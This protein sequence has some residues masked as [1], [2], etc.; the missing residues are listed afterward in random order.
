MN[1]AIIGANGFIGKHLVNQLS[2]N[3]FNQL[4]LFGT[5]KV[6]PFSN[7]YWYSS[8]DLKNTAELLSLFKDIDIVY[9]LASASIPAS[10]WENPIAEIENNLL[11]FINFLECISKL[12][13]K[14]IIF[15]SSAGTIYGSSNENLSEDSNKKPFSPHGINK[16][17]M[18]YYLN[19]FEAKYGLKY[20]VFRV[21]NIYGEG[22][23]TSKG[24]GIIN[25]FLEKIISEQKITVFGDGEIIRNYIYVKDVAKALSYAS[26]LNIEKSSIY[27]LS[28]DDSLSIKEVIEQI[29]K[30][31]KEDFQINFKEI[32]G[33]DNPKILL[34]N[35][36]LKNDFKELK[37][38]SITEGIQNTYLNLLHK[39]Q[40][41]P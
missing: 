7:E 32:R 3:S 39:T 33:S 23:N 36:K 26:N 21:S 11:P 38:T 20:D 13:V 24:L 27:N 28:S 15:T 19:Y 10:T 14:K 6:S 18:E 12:S 41:Q 25:T 22:Q 35:S 2:E 4:F 30:I 9:Y 31:T 5:N 29:K 8:I 17:T 34:D 1:I 40:S 16:V 37:F